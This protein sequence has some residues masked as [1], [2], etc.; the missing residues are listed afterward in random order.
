MP[1]LIMCERLC[2]FCQIDIDMNTHHFGG[3]S[4]GRGGGFLFSEQV[5]IAYWDAMLLRA[6]SP[7]FTSCARFSRYHSLLALTLP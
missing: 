5:L 1:R 3:L 4:R 6:S 7:L 2:S